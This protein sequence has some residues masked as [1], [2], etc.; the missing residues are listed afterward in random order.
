[1]KPMAAIFPIGVIRP[2][3]FSDVADILEEVLKVS[4][5]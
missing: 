5:D 1:M 2:Q 4:G 3:I